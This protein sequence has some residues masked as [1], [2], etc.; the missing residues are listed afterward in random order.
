MKKYPFIL[1]FDIDC[2]VIGDI[3]FLIQEAHILKY[4]YNICEK[5]NENNCKFIEKINMQNE[6][7]NGLLRPYIKDFIEFCNNKFKNV[8]IFFYT[9][10]NYGWTNSSL[11]NNIEKAL[12]VKINRPFFTRENLILTSNSKE[13][14]LANIFPFITSTLENRYPVMKNKQDIDYIINNRTIFIDDVK[15]NTYT[16][17]N[18]Q[19]VCP[20]YKCLP[21]CYIPD[22]IIK[23]YN[24]DPK[25]FDNKELL[26][27]MWKN[28]ICVYNVNGNV[29]QRSLEYFNLHKMYNVKYCE[30]SKIDD[31]FYKD[32]IK[33]LS[34]KYVKNYEISNNN[35][36]SI[37]KKLSQIDYSLHV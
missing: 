33:E 13:K 15:N 21:W 18:R 34:K 25:V 14:S 16:H 10:S 20:E 5:N 32:L 30:L 7:N 27:Y 12:N 19:I 26:D 37:N 22:K 1:I 2:T 11:G 3:R 8:E 28:N 23:E 29:Y 36:F 24:I 31:M 6:L 4:I 35:I 17:V 9:G